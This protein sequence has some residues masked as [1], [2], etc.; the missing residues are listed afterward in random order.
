[1]KDLL[2]FATPKGRQGTFFKKPV[3]LYTIDMFYNEEFLGHIRQSDDYHYWTI[4]WRLDG[5]D[6][7]H[8]VPIHSQENRIA[9]AMMFA[10]R[11]MEPK[12]KAYEA[13]LAEDE[14]KWLAEDVFDA[15]AS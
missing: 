11:F 2:L 4:E 6:N 8:M 14:E 1:M 12:L 7:S 15:D 3:I 10:A 9:M 5:E 13:K